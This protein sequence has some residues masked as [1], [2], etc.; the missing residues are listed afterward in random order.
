MTKADIVDKVSDA[1]GFT[2]KDSV[3]LVDQV[4]ETVKA[5]LETSSTVKIPGFGNFVVKEKA[6][7]RGR[8][9]RTGDEIVIESRKVLTFKPS[10]ILKQRVNQ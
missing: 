6:E 9:P 2:K 10:E 7:R 5:A 4:F 8:N 3:E 1:T